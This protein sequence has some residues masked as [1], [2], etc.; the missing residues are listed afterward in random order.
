[1]I[2]LEGFEL[3]ATANLQQETRLAKAEVTMKASLPMSTLALTTNPTEATI[4]EGNDL[5]LSATSSLSENP[6]HFVWYNS[7]LSSVLATETITSGNTATTTVSGLTQDT[8]IYV[9]VGTDEVCPAYPLSSKVNISELRLDMTVN[10]DTTLLTAVDSVLFYDENGPNLPYSYSSENTMIHHTFKANSGHVK[11]KFSEMSLTDCDDIFLAVLEGNLDEENIV[12]YYTADEIGADDSLITSVGNTLTVVWM[13]D[14]IHYNEPHNGWKASVYTDEL[15]NAD[16]NVLARTDVNVN[17]SFHHVIYDT[18]CASSIPYSIDRFQNIDISTGGEYEIDSVY[19]TDLGCDSTYSLKLKV[20]EL[21]LDGIVS[22][23]VSC[24]NAMDGS[25]T[26]SDENVVGGITPFDFTLTLEG[27]TID[28]REQL[29]PGNYLI[30]VKDRFGCS[31]SETITISQPDEL[32]FTNCPDDLTYNVE[33]GQDG[34]EIMLTQPQFAPT[35]NNPIVTTSGIPSDNYYTVGTH[36]I[37]YTVTNDCGEE[38]VCTF[39]L[40]VN[41]ATKPITIISNNQSWTYDGY[42]HLGESFTVWYGDDELTADDNSNG[43]IFTIPV[44][45]DKLTITPTA[46]VIDFTPTPVTNTFEYVLQNANYYENVTTENGTLSISKRNVSITV[47]AENASKM[48]DGDSL[49]VTF[50]DIMIDQLADRD[51]LIAGFVITE[52]FV[53]GEYVCSDGNFMAGDGIASQHGFD[54]VHGDGDGYSAGSSLVNYTPTFDI[55]LRITA[56]PLTITALSDTKVYDGTALTASYELSSTED[57]IL[58]EGDAVQAETIGSQTCVGTSP[59]TVAEGYKVMH[60]S[61]VDGVTATEDVTSSYDISTVNGTLT[62]TPITTGFDCPASLPITLNEGTADTTLT[63]T[64]L[65][66][67]TLNGSALPDYVTAS[68]DLAAQNP[69]A[70]GT[71]T[72]TWTLRDNC[73]NAM[74]TCTQTVEVSYQPCEGTV[75]MANSSYHYKRIG[76]QC[77]F[78]ENLREETG[79]HHAYKDNAANVAD[80]GYLYSW[81]TTVGV[82]EGDDNAEPDNT[83]VGADGQHYV[84]GICPDG[85]SVGSASDYAT[86]NA[87][88]PVNLLKDPSTQYWLNGYEGTPGGSGFNA[89]GSGWFNSALNRYEDFKTGFH[90]WN[91]D[92]T[93]GSSTASAGTV[94]YYCDS[95]ATETASKRDLRSVRCV[96]KVNP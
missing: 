23:N 77:W 6:Q 84:Q 37:T 24:R 68:S 16:M 39:T 3:V 79:E 17:S 34:I 83:T 46:S 10:G 69:L 54:I 47:N 91:S 1:L 55:T 89:R 27:E 19:Q 31:I 90:F 12:A 15:L 73:G 96:R 32:H 88:V 93:P 94:N 11:I 86:L 56:R 43:R 64:Q 21:G 33:I 35:D 9:A 92:S 4:C 72:I 13:S 50:D 22:T 65:G 78:T 25:I 61:I 95:I 53:V 76:H 36:T 57:P 66:T 40:T 74:T 60:T 41:P 29:S 18:V 63:A 85:W 8:T 52:G 67:P 2:P 59:N 5:A 70:E 14:H 38:D 42:V 7:D 28:R 45:G 49:K 71:H 20:V 75:T 80:Y 30:S 82:T 26:I 51:Q 81:Y 48:Y 62:V 58:G 87:A 44:T